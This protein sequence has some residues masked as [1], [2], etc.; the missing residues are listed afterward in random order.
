MQ[1]RRQLSGVL[2]LVLAA[3][4]FIIPVTGCSYVAPTLLPISAEASFD[5]SQEGAIAE[6]EFHVWCNDRYIVNIS[7][8]TFGASFYDNPIIQYLGGWQIHSRPGAQ[9][10]LH[11]SIVKLTYRGEEVITDTVKNGG[12]IYTLP[13]TNSLGV[14]N[15][16]P[17]K[18]RLRVTNLK[19]HRQLKYVP[20]KIFMWYFRVK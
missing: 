15:L 14:Y 20:V 16:S 2:Q 18:Y 3:L 13:I 11:V 7:Y 5:L 19:G 9:V 6:T 8:D 17:G 10:P 4:I 1:S 12:G